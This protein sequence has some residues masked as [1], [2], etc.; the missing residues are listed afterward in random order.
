MG[1]LAQLGY[2][3]PGQYYLTPQVEMRQPGRAMTPVRLQ[4]R[5]RVQGRQP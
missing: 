5:Y 3:R 4:L 2:L 1:R